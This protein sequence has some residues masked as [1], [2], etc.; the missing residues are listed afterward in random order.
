MTVNAFMLMK[1][2]NEVLID[3][4][5]LDVLLGAEVGFKCSE[6]AVCVLV[7]R[8]IERVVDRDRVGEG[9]WLGFGFVSWQGYGM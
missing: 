3:D 9:D 4:D 5:Q 7:G 2:E 6:K 1:N 8:W